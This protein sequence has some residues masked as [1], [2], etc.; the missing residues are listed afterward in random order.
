MATRLQT[1]TRRGPDTRQRILRAAEHLFADEGFGRV[2]LRQIARASQQRNV[3]AVQYHFG[4][5]DGLLTAIVDQHRAEL[6]ED[7]RAMLAEFDASG[8]S[9]GLSQLLSILVAPL[10]KKLDNSSG[11]AYLRIQAEGLHDEAMRPAT[12]NVVTRISH[13]LRGTGQAKQTPYVDRFVTLLLFHA[14]ADRARQ[15]EGSTPTGD[16]TAFLAALKQSLI[17]L[18]HAEPTSPDSPPAKSGR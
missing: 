7:R 10:C 13:E 12:R 3:A 9:T 5:K 8:Q 11:R 1:L 15:E 14:L 4:S 16:R 2:T 18:L 17:A 6:D